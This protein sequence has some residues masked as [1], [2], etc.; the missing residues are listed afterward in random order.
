MLL[1][2]FSSFFLSARSILCDISVLAYNFEPRYA[3]SSR[4]IYHISVISIQFR[5]VSD[6]CFVSVVTLGKTRLRLSPAAPRDRF[7]KMKRRDGPFSGETDARW[8]LSERH[9]RRL[10]ERALRSLAHSLAHSLGRG[11]SKV[12]LSI[13][14]AIFARLGPRRALYYQ[15]IRSCEV[16]CERP[17]R[18][19][20]AKEI[21]IK[22]GRATST[23][24][25]GRE[26]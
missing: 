26:E 1:S 6:S 19:R 18:P 21:G 14:I 4:R 24:L 13:L 15:L 3:R 5:D 23:R 25:G 9:C 12:A 8:H 20:C 11:S 16:C 7:I 22:K 2:S 10:R 17:V